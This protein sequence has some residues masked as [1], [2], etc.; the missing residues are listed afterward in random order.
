MTDLIKASQGNQQAFDNI[1]AEYNGKA[2]K[3]AGIYVAEHCEDIV[4]DVW[5]KILDKRHLL[6]DI[7]NFENWLFFVVR[8]A[9][10]NFLKVEKRRRNNFSAALHENIS[11]SGV[12]YYEMLDKI[13]RDENTERLRKIMKNLPE[14]YSLPLL[15]QYAKGMTLAEIANMLNLPLSTVKWRIHSG[16]LQIKKEYLKGGHFYVK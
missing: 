15:M 9:C 7:E 11:D 16:K 4:Q 1:V 6:G 8:N 5:I 13:I 3:I 2:L 14:M 12:N 10:F